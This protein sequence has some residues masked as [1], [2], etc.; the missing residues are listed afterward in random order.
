M[1]F[2]FTD[3]QDHLRSEVRKFLANSSPLPRIRELIESPSSPGSD[4]NLWNQM[5]TLGWIGLC[6]PEKHGGAG[7]DLETLIVVL[8]ETGR[9]LLP[10]PLIST[11]LAAKAVDRFGSEAQ[12]SRWLPSLA[13]GSRI[14]TS[15][16]LERGD[17][18]S[19]DGIATTARRD[20]DALILSGEKLFVPDPAVADLFVVPVRTGDDDRPTDAIS[21]VVLD[22]NT[23]GLS[24][25]P[26]AAMDPTKPMGSLTL[27]TSAS[28]WTTSSA[29]WAKPGPP[30]NDSSISAPP[31]SP[32]KPS[33][34]P[35]PR[36][37]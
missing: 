3:D 16:F 2:G 24:I 31:S 35:K 6:L 37:T 4:P 5:A 8:E 7:L 23:P 30:P 18:L 29:P 15:A 20:G 12:Q 22:R 33:A 36:S 27:R 14:G 11:V 32:P 13:N 26:H 19:P 9:T 17:S 21:L 10:S 1:N 25:S 34:P 28:P